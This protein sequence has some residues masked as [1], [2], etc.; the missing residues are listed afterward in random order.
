MTEDTAVWTRFLETD[1]W[2]LRRVWYDVRV[3]QSVLGNVEVSPRERRIAE[4][5]TRKRIDVVAQVGA[6]FWVIEV[7]PFAN[8]K[9]LGQALTYSRLFEKEYTVSGEVIPVIVCNEYDVDI[10]P[11]FDDY[12]VLVLQNE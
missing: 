4:G 9:A 8:M 12:G 6:G 11:E 5:L 3:G 10:L 1:G 7:K 2:R